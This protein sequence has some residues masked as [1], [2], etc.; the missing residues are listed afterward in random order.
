MSESSSFTMDSL[1][2]AKLLTKAGGP[3]KTTSELMNGKDL[4]L[5]YFSASWCPPCKAFSPILVSFYNACS[6]DGKLEIV[7]VSSD[8]TVPDFEGYFKK[9]PWLSIP[10]E[11]GSAAIKNA[12][13]QKLGIQ[14][15][16]ALIVLDAKTGEF[17]SANGREDVTNVGADKSAGTALI[18]KW[19]SMER[20]PFSEAAQAAGGSQNPLIQIVMFFAKNPMSVFALMYLYRYVKKYFNTKN[21]IEDAPEDEAA[22]PPEVAEEESEF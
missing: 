1:L 4:L 8:R 10:T 9:M 16:P 3:K 6:K 18:A 19:K 7:Y 14:G 11:E 22:G 2:G 20:R 17:I 12:L 15:I 21:G 5:L 13:S